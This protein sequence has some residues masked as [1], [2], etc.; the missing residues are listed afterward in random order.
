MN[1]TPDNHTHHTATTDYT[2]GLRQ[3]DLAAALALD[4]AAVAQALE[5][6]DH[7]A[8]EAESAKDRVMPVS[9]LTR[10]FGARVPLTLILLLG[11]AGGHMPWQAAL[12]VV[13][14]SESV[15]ALATVTRNRAP[16]RSTSQEKPA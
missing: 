12:A 6:C 16:R 2:T 14:A 8:R 11:S 7:P 13:V 1:H 5:Q 4:H 9:Q 3:A 10:R 15:V